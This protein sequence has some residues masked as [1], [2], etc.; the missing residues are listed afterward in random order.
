MVLALAFWVTGA[1]SLAAEALC[2]LADG[3]HPAESCAGCPDED[4]GL[5]CSP[6]CIPGPAV[7]LAPPEASSP[8]QT[9]LT[10]P[11]GDRSPSPVLDGL[12]RPPCA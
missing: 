8:C 2:P 7:A 3:E 6:L 5:P 9:T 11:P 12:L 1:G 10:S 4:E